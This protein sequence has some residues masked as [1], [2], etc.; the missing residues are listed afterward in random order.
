M[1][2]RTCC[3]GTAVRV[4]TH[5]A[6]CS[7]FLGVREQPAEHW[8]PGS[9]IGTAWRYRKCGAAEVLRSGVVRSGR[10][11]G[12]SVSAGPLLRPASRS[13]RTLADMEAAC[14]AP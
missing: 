4:A 14:E 7:K 9:G 3:T 1:T 12:V 13:G 11:A 10:G 8:Y 6:R 2:T 5:H